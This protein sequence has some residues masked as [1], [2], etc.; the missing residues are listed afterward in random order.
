[1]DPWEPPVNERFDE[2][3]QDKEGAIIERASKVME[4]GHKLHV[5][6]IDLWLTS[7]LQNE[8][9]GTCPLCRKVLIIATSKKDN[10]STNEGIGA[11]ILKIALKV[12]R[13]ALIIL[14][15]IPFLIYKGI[16][17]VVKIIIRR[18]TEYTS[19]RA[20]PPRSS[21]VIRAGVRRP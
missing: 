18:V 10:E 9:D 4:C 7:Q 15:A 2:Q 14:L 8:S 17:A 21:L 3:K 12:L 11:K 20:S 16:E 13:I 6:C 1:M 19:N 5:D